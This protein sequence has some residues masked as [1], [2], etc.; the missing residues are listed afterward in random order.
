MATRKKKGGITQENR[1]RVHWNAAYSPKQLRDRVEEYIEKCNKDTRS[2]DPKTGLTI[3]KPILKGGLCLFLGVGINYF[4]QLREH[5]VDGFKEVLDWID[6]IVNNDI[7]ERLATG[8]GNTTGLIFL[9]KNR[10]GMVDKLEVKSE[11]DNKI[12]IKF[13]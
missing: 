8:Q 2:V 3:K 5:D 1:I 9:A 12:E 11:V 10:N 13:S 6:L 7:E 4:S